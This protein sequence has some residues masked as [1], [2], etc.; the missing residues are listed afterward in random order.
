MWLYDRF[1]VKSVML[2]KTIES[3]SS[4][5]PCLKKIK[6]RVVFSRRLLRSTILVFYFLF[7]VGVIDPR[8]F[9]ITSST[10]GKSS[11]AY[12]KKHPPVVMSLYRKITALAFVDSWVFEV[13]KPNLIDLSLKRYTPTG[14][15][16]VYGKVVRPRQV[17]VLTYLDPG[18]EYFVP[19]VGLTEVMLTMTGSNNAQP[20]RESDAE[21]P[22]AQSAR[23]QFYF[24][25]LFI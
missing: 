2:S 5:V 8:V 13:A 19:K 6:Y 24:Q 11:A 4:Q 25:S 12:V 17:G 9:N 23:S 7:L 16:L 21:G 18:L 10:Q 22:V 3:K 15:L 20:V 1:V 14:C